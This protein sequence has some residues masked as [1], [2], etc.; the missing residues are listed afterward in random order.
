M[1]CA[2]IKEQLEAV[3]DRAVGPELE[4]A[5]MLHLSACSSC[6][7]E[8]ARLQALRSVLLVSPSPEPPASLEARVMNAFYQARSKRRETRSW[9]HSLVF[10]SIKIPKPAFALVLLGVLSALALALQI[11]RMMATPI[12]VTMSPPALLEVAPAPQPTKIVE[13]PDEKVSKSREAS[14]VAARRPPVARATRERHPPRPSQARPLEN[15]TVISAAGTNYATRATLKDF[16]PIANATVR[17]I[18]GKGE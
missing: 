7:D 16:E 14:Q 13:A 18:K 8:W 9:W 12:V 5:V 15:L 2:E 4:K 6:Q 1:N 17:V 3:L 10:G 11:G